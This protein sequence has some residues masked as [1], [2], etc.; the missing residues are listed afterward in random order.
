MLIYI[1]FNFDFLGINFNFDFFNFD[2]R[3]RVVSDIQTRAELSPSAR[4]CISDTTRP[5]ML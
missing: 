3:V 5:L 1:N 2:F 4:V